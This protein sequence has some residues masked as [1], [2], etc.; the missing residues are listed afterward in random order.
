MR[1]S[2][3]LF[4]WVLLVLATVAELALF[5]IPLDRTVFTVALFG[6]AGLKA[7]MI[8]V[9]YQQVIREGRDVAAFYLFALLVA[10]GLIIGTLTSMSGMTT[11]HV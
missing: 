6:L 2:T 3:A 10:L 4:V 9:F 5:R 8:A 7:L 1:F 11:T